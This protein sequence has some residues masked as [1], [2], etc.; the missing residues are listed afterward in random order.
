[1][2]FFD[3]HSL[4]VLVILMLCYVHWDKDGG[5]VNWPGHILTLAQLDCVPYWVVLK[6]K[7]LDFTVEY[8]S[9]VRL[10]TTC[11]TSPQLKGK[12]KG[13]SYIAC[14]LIT[15]ASFCDYFQTLKNK[16]LKSFTPMY[17][18]MRRRNQPEF[19]LFKTTLLCSECVNAYYT[20]RHR[21]WAAALLN[22]RSPI[23]LISEG[24]WEQPNISSGSSLA[25][26]IDFT[27]T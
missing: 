5:P 11:N 27:S 15:T 16:L 22:G 7:T 21:R 24:H 12:E 3:S 9:G 23:L 19:F 2:Y 25:L 17:T 10:G 1:M 18:T 14:A 8:S 13:W 20:F 4:V 6:K 26:H